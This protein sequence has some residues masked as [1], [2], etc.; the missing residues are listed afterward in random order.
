MHLS[1]A[2]RVRRGYERQRIA[3][4]RAICQGNGR[5][6]AGQYD[7]APAGRGWYQR[8]RGA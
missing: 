6:L 7:V 5:Y 2:Y 1:R 4:G 8:A 3:A